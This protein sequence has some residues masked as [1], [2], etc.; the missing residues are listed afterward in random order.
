MRSLFG[1]II[2]LAVGLVF[3]DKFAVAQRGV[4]ERS[5][6]E[7]PVPRWNEREQI[8]P[9]EIPPPPLQPICSRIC[10]LVNVEDCRRRGLSDN[11]NGMACHDHCD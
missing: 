7:R 1:G 9:I 2:V 11:C 5:P 6:T 4:G 10:Y 8:P 3:A